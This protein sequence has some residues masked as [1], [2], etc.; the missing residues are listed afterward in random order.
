MTN[1]CTTY[2]IE[3]IGD[4]GAPDRLQINLLDTQK[5]GAIDPRDRLFALPGV[6]TDGDDTALHLGYH[7][8]KTTQDT[9]TNHVTYLIARDRWLKKLHAAGTGFPRSLVNLPSWVVNWSCSLG[10]T[11]FE[12]VAIRVEYRAKG[13]SEV[14]VLEGTKNSDLPELMIEGCVVDKIKMVYWPSSEHVNSADPS[15]SKPLRREEFA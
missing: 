7:E 15:L 2:S 1:I 3:A 10:G 4:F 13:I 8:S 6:V 11:T 9:R 14:Q 5:F 12:A